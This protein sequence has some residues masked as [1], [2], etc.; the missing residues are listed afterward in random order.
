MKKPSLIVSLSIYGIVIL[1]FASGYTY[2]S[3][4]ESKYLATPVLGQSTAVQQKLENVKKEQPKAFY[5]LALANDKPVQQEGGSAPN[6]DRL[7]MAAPVAAAPMVEA[8]K[9]IP[10]DMKPVVDVDYGQLLKN[11]LKLQAIIPEMK[12]GVINGKLYKEGDALEG[13]KSMWINAKDSKGN[14][15]PLPKLVKVQNTQVTVHSIFG[16]VVLKQAN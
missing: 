7:F 5:P 2:F 8:P 11:S 12:S 10:A 4:L 16:T 6:L 1:G 9:E 15:A 13:L 14:T 3:K